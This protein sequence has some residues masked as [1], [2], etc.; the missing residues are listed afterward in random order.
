MWCGS[1]REVFI[2]PNSYYGR[3][4]KKL[5][6]WSFYLFEIEAGHPGYVRSSADR[7]EDHRT[8]KYFARIR[9][10]ITLDIPTP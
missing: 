1:Q 9:N 5:F 6:E 10:S 8:K 3:Q 2:D 4:A 7:L